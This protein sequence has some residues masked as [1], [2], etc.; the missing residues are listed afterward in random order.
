MLQ[1]KKIENNVWAFA[2]VYYF[3][4]KALMWKWLIIITLYNRL[5]Y[6]DVKDGNK[7]PISGKFRPLLTNPVAQN[8]LL[9]VLFIQ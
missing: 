2:S 8:Q 1:K 4:M 6:F 7:V 5:Y 3:L 9:S